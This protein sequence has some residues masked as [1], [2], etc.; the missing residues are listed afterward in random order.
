MGM[1]AA[2][3]APEISL[4]TFNLLDTRRPGLFWFDHAHDITVGILTPATLPGWG[5]GR[6]PFTHL[7]ESRSAVTTIIC[8]VPTYLTPALVEMTDNCRVELRLLQL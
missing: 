5:L 2:H 8:N 1:S 7:S 4:A 3:G 6:A